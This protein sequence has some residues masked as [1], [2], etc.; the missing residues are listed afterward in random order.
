MQERET[1]RGRK[2]EVVGTGATPA[3]E[4]DGKPVCVG[5]DP[6]SGRF[7]AGEAPFVPY[8]T[9]LEVGRAI[10]DAREEVA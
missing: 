9:L 1:Y 7:H 10:V 4:I 8:E 5:R 2:V 6:D 3:V